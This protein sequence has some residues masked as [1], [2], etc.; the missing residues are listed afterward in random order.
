M[1]SFEGIYEI[2]EGLGDM[3][4]D[5]V[6]SSQVTFLWGHVFIEVGSWAL[7]RAYSSSSLFH[8]HCAVRVIG[9]HF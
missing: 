6:L 9:A 7:S 4:L 8:S 5:A 3:I 1:V 2:T